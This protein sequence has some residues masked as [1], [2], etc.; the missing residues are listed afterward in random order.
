MDGRT[1]GQTDGQKKR[2]VESRSTRLKIVCS[3][4]YIM[5]VHCV[6][7][8]TLPFE[9]LMVVRRQTFYA[10]ANKFGGFSADDFLRNCNLF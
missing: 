8:L 7:V 10:R 5:S 4:I 1:D 9:N 6:H 3:I 2:V